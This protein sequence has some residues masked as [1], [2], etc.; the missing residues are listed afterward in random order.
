MKKH[1][2]GVAIALIIIISAG[3]LLWI[4]V[5]NKDASDLYTACSNYVYSDDSETLQT[6]IQKAHSLYTLNNRGDTGEN[7]LAQFGNIIDKINTFE[8]DLVS[9]LTLDN[10]KSSKIS[11]SYKSLSGSREHLINELTIYITRMSSNT[12]VGNSATIKNLYEDILL[13]TVDFVKQYN[14]CFESSVNYVFTEVYTTSNIKRELYLLYS[15]CVSDVINTMSSKQFPNM[16]VVNKLNSS[17]KLEYSCI[18]FASTISG[19]EFS[20]EALKFKQYFNQ[21]S[22]TNFASNFITYYN[23]TNSGFSPKDETSNEK[24]AMYYLKKILEM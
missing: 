17:I 24:L 10:N 19:G 5:F 23:E 9:Y 13:S 8:K 1:I 3:A 18:Q 11:K 12:E 16:P 22:L 4:F 14:S 21:G 6:S 2:I 15:A 20:K 7:R